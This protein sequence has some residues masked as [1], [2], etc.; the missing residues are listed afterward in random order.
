MTANSIYQN[1]LALLGEEAGSAL[2]LQLPAPAVISLMAAEL[3]KINNNIRESKGLLPLS[4]I[5][6]VCE[7]DDE[8]PF[9]HEVLAAM[10]YGLAARLIAEED[11]GRGMSF[12]SHYENKLRSVRKASVKQI[13]ELL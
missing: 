1:S 8:L 11:P 2:R 7:L 12:D 4:E 5:P 10:A 13:N 9:E 6:S 3:F